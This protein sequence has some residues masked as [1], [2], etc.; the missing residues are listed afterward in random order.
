[1][2]DRELQK[3]LGQDTKWRQTNTKSQDTNKTDV[4][5]GPY[6]NVKCEPMCS[7]RVT[8]SYKVWTNVLAKVTSSY[9]V[10]TNVLV[11]GNQFL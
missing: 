4:Q 3:T 9:K 8:S 6:Q 2:D 1:M 10:W 5:H 7:R 11:K